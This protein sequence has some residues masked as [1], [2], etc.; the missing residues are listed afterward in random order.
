MPASLEGGAARWLLHLAAPLG[1]TP[2]LDGATALPFVENA[3][4][5]CC[6]RL[7]GGVLLG[8]AQFRCAKR[9]VTSIIPIM[10]LIFEFHYLRLHVIL[11]V[12]VTLN[13]SSSDTPRSFNTIDGR[14]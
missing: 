5:S 1:G 11:G 13:F 3:V 12:V 2:H 14:R 10:D 6:P 4:Q 9:V 7:S 8:W